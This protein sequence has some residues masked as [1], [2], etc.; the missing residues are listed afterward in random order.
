[1]GSTTRLSA[2]QTKRRG[3]AASIH[4]H[5]VALALVRQRRELLALLRADISP[6]EHIDTLNRLMD[7]ELVARKIQFSPVVPILRNQ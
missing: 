5:C 1:M 6:E 2:L 7:L 3:L 4:L